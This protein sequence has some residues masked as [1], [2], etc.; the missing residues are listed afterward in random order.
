MAT[1]RTD[2]WDEASVAR[3]PPRLR[4]PR[5]SPL[6]ARRPSV[7]SQW[8]VRRCDAWPL[9]RVRARVRTR[10]RVRARARVGVRVRWL[11]LGCGAWHPSLGHRRQIAETSPP[12]ACRQYSAPR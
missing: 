1:A 4:R 5:A 3:C 12:W 9:V 11:G 10:V 2:A 7:S 8:S 6:L